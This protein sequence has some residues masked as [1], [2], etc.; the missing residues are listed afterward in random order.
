M[1]N[2]VNGKKFTNEQA[3]DAL[4]A[5]NGNFTKAAEMCGV[6]RKTFAD[7]VAGNP[8]L[9]ELVEELRDGVLDQA[10]ENFANGVMN[11]DLGASKMMLETIGKGRGYVKRQELSD[12]DGR[13]MMAGVVDEVERLIAR[14]AS[15]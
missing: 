12:P 11:G 5:C 13:S 14:H 10:E 8:V 4:R 15:S 2:V 3:Y 7:R 1:T 6:R 9:L